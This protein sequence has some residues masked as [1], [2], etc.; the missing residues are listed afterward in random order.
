LQHGA[1]NPRLLTCHQC[2]KW[3]SPNVACLRLSGESHSDV[4]SSQCTL[5]F[6][7]E[8]RHRPSF[9]PSPP[10]PFIFQ[11]TVV[12]P[13]NFTALYLALSKFLHSSPSFASSSP[14]S[15][16]LP[17]YPHLPL[18]LSYRS[19]KSFVSAFAH[20]QHIL[21]LLN[22][23]LHLFSSFPPSDESDLSHELPA[24][25]A[26]FSTMSTSAFFWSWGA[27]AHTLHNGW[28]ASRS[29]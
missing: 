14:F 13:L 9:I 24:G 8:S 28:R 4:V 21:I 2:D 26:S 5:P 23:S 19:L 7:S 25:P 18:I 11:V 16:I 6:P 10:S 15:C 27:R 20:D 22:L 12:F 29:S 3:V 1:Q 17:L